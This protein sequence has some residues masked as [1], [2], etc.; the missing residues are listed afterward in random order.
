VTGSLSIYK[1]YQLAL[2]SASGPVYSSPAMGPDGKI[3][4][5]SQGEYLVILPNT[6]SIVDTAPA[7]PVWA[8]SVVDYANNKVYF[9]DNRG[10]LHV[11]YPDKLSYKISNYSIYA[12]PV[13]IGDYVYVVDLAGR[14]IKVSKSNPSNY[15]IIRNLN[16]EVRSSPVVVDGK[17]FVATVDG[18]IYAID[19]SGNIVWQKGFSDEFRRKR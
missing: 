15:T 2:I 11:Y 17:L 1:K 6:Y 19:P 4:I 13:I 12:A 14:V 9:A 7:S 5:G 3:Y 10:Y 8:S 16:K 18:Y